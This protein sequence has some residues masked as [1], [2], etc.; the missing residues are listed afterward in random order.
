M[1]RLELPPALFRT[2]RVVMEKA[3]RIQYKPYL[4]LRGGKVGRFLEGRLYQQIYRRRGGAAESDYMPEIPA[5]LQPF[6][7]S[8]ADAAARAKHHGNT[9]LGK[10]DSWFLKHQCRC[11]RRMSDARISDPVRHP[12]FSRLMSLEEPQCLIE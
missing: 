8:T 5:C 1:G 3:G 9:A 10:R 7:Q 11:C 4:S 12:D 2:M 6:D